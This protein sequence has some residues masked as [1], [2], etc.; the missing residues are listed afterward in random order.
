MNQSRVPPVQTPMISI[1]LVVGESGRQTT[2]Q[3]HLTP[4]VAREVA[5]V[6]N[7]AAQLADRTAQGQTRFLNL[8]HRYRGGHASPGSTKG[9]QWVEKWHIS[10]TV[11]VEGGK[12]RG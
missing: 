6:L 10:P 1:L 8:S 3:A 4:D 5:R 9:E 7:E 2:V 12:T 11:A